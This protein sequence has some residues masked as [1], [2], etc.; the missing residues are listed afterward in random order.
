RGGE[1]LQRGASAGAGT[2][3]ALVLRRQTPELALALA[4]VTGAL[5]LWRSREALETV[6]SLFKELAD[7]AGLSQEMLSPLV[8]TVGIAL[9]VR[10]ASQLCRDGGMGSGAAFLELAGSLAALVTVAPLLRAVL[11]LVEELL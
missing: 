7:L 4:L 2:F 5:L 6:L 11:D 8:K 3:C 1:M 9:L 10:I